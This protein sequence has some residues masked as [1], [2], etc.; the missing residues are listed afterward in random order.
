MAQ[1]YGRIEAQYDTWVAYVV[2]FP[3][4]IA[5]IVWLISG[6]F[7][8]FVNA[9]DAV[10]GTGDLLTVGILILLSAVADSDTVEAFSGPRDRTLSRLK[11]GGI[12]GAL[13]FGML[14]AV[15]KEYG[16]K[17]LARPEQSQLELRAIAWVSIASL[18]LMVA[19]ATYLRSAAMKHEFNF[20]LMS[21]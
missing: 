5:L 18:V 11:T 17:L 16:L 2:A 20:T 19:Y 6:L 8:G 13:S 15:F 12:L 4:V 14:F 7:L 1:P 3:I 10:Y 21:R 9:F